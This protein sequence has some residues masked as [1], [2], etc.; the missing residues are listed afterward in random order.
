[1]HIFLCKCPG[2][3]Q[4]L[5]FSFLK[6]YLH[7]SNSQNIKTWNTPGRNLLVPKKVTYYLCWFLWPPFWYDKSTIE[8]HTRLLELK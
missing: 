7:D 8:D 5:I 3:S 6:V 4:S 2:I 1:M